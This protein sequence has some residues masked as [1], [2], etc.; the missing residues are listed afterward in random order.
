MNDDVYI[1][2][3]ISAFEYTINDL[4]MGRYTFHL[5]FLF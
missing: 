2:L 3:M 1:Q 4:C 5:N